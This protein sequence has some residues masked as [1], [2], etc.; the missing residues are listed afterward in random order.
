MIGLI[1]N[2]DLKEDSSTLLYIIPL[3]WEE[4]V[5]LLHAHILSWNQVPE[6]GSGNDYTV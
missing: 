1:L 6:A 5:P 3:H 4:N 2:F